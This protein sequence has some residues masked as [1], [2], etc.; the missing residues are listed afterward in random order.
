MKSGNSAGGN[1][2]LLHEQHEELQAENSAVPHIIELPKISDPRG[3]LTF[4]ES[5]N[6]LPF[7]IRRVFYLYDVP[8]G[9]DRGGHALKS[10]SQLLVAISGSFDVTTDDGKQK[11]TFH[12]ARSYYG[13]YIPPLTWREMFNFSSGSVCLVLASENYSPAGYIRSEQEFR[14]SVRQSATNL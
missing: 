6:H 3:N 5:N 13:L 12:L 10:C 9:S 2:V 4:I 11:Q 8:G 7:E 1:V 14:K